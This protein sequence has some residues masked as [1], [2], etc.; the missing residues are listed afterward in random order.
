ML[1]RPPSSTRTDTLFPYSTLFRS[2]RGAEGARNPVGYRPAHH[3]AAALR[4]ALSRRT[5]PTL[6][7]AAR[8]VPVRPYRRAEKASGDALGR[9][10]AARGGRSSEEPTS[11]LPSLMRISYAV[12]CL[13]K[14]TIPTYNT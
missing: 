6:A 5:A 1:P 9:P 8:A 4:P 11:E 3:P 2:A 12:F 13:K 10:A 7:A 14:K